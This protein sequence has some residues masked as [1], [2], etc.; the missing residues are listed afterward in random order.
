MVLWIIREIARVRLAN[1]L[2][3][4]CQIIGILSLVNNRS[5]SSVSTPNSCMK[6]RNIPDEVVDIRAFLC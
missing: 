4:S 5:I 6:V 1:T 3:T 2:L